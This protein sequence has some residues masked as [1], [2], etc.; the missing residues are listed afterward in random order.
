[1]VTKG[2]LRVA[3]RFQKNEVDR[4]NRLTDGR[5]AIARMIGFGEYSRGAHLGLI[6]LANRWCRPQD[7]EC[8]ECPLRFHCEA[9]KENLELLPTLFQRKLET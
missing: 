5:L 6:E 4:R 9:G 7:P 2:V 3:S 8:P 1:L